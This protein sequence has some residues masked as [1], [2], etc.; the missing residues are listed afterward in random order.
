VFLP[1]PNNSHAPSPVAAGIDALAGF[2][3]RYIVASAGFSGQVRV[4]E[5]YVRT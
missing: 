3:L 1:L 2:G 4:H 5:L